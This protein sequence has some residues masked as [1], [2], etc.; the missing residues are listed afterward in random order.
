M[1]QFDYAVVSSI[2]H[3]KDAV[4]AIFSAYEPF[5]SGLEGHR[6]ELNP[7]AGDT[8]PIFFI[9]TGGT[10][11]IVLDYLNSSP[12]PRSGKPFPLILIAHPRHNSLPA[13]LEIAAH[14]GQKGGSAIVIQL[15]SPDDDSS[16][17]EIKAAVEICAAIKAMRNSVI[18]AVGEP[19]DW[20]VASS[21]KPDAVSSVWGARIEPVAFR[22]LRDK[23]DEL[24]REGPLCLDAQFEAFLEGA[25]FVKEP[26]EADM[27]KSDGIYKALRQVVTEKDLD[28][29][30]LRCFDLVLLDQSTGCY[31]LS[32]LADDGV[33]AGCEG[34][35]PSIIALRWMR[36]L[37]GRAAWMANPS[38]IR[39]GEAGGEGSVLL[40]HCT[41]P[42]SLLASYGIRSHFESGLGLAVAGDFAPGPVTLVRL[43]GSSMDKAWIAEGFLAPGPSDEGLCRTQ[44]LIQMENA[45][46][47]KLL[48]RPL[49]NHIVV[50]FG[51][52]AKKARRYLALEHIE[53]I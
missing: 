4:E 29:L 35:I 16:R 15:K 24:G 51:H 25:R 30:T 5:F 21:Q 12:A 22:E 13:A 7:S 47:T 45:D 53:E 52:W 36:L 34:D 2:L 28:G 9:L 11:G 39:L 19:S 20:L 41:V 40:A 26:A 14:A 37:S 49:G 50:G 18:G 43:G 38:E 44:A 8:P 3:N 32:Q 27:R 46:L 31:A 17:G 6:I 23:I 42:R 48:E 33:D 1:S 10:E